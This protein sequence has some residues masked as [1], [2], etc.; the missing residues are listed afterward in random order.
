MYRV[1]M[2]ALTVGVVAGC[3]QTAVKAPQATEFILQCD[4]EGTYRSGED[5]RRYDHRYTVRFDLAAGT[6]LI[7]SNEKKEFSELTPGVRAKLEVSPTLLLYQMEFGDQTEGSR[8]TYRF[9]RT[10]GTLSVD[11]GSWMPESDFG[12]AIRQFHTFEGRC[13]KIDQPSSE[14]KF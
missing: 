10:L 14:T 5:F 9:A 7:W 13:E 3:G 4:G 11:A 8:D 2:A 6:M 1:V 12:P